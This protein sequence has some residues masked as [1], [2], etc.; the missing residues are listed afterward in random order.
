MLEQVL[1]KVNKYD[2]GLNKVKKCVNSNTIEI[3][4]LKEIKMRW[5]VK[6]LIALKSEVR[7]LNS[8]LR[9]KNIMLLNIKNVRD[10][11]D[12]LRNRM[13]D[14]VKE[15]GRFEHKH[16]VGERSVE[17][18][19]VSQNLKIFFHNLNLFKDKGIT[20]SIDTTK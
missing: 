11:N 18:T 3:V 19:L 12:N 15:I 5:K 2:N 7:F 1:K 14:M 8:S 13:L 10:I 9:A 20:V 6:Y 17:I 4:K 16:N